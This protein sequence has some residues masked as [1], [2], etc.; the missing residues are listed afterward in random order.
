MSYLQRSCP[1]C[2][3]NNKVAQVISSPIKA[4]LLSFDQ[5]KSYWSGFFKEKSFFSY[6]R[7][8]CGLLYCPSFFNQDQL[9]SLYKSMSDN[10]AGVP[11]TALNKTQKS[12]F[13]ILKKHSDLSGQ[14]LEFGPDIGLFTQNCINQGNFSQYWLCEPNQEVWNALQQKLTG[15]IY[16]IFSGMSELNRIPDHS[17][18]TL[19]MIHVLDHLLD[20]MDTLEKIKTKLAPKATLM[21]VTHDERSF[22]A[23][24]AKSKW[25]PYCLQHPQLFNNDSITTLLKKAGFNEVIC[26]KS[27]NYFPITYLIKHA[28]YLL[29]FKNI[30]LPKLDRLQMG[31]KLGNMITIAKLV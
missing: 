28:L 18:S 26:E 22:L 4:E 6:F 14:Y 8:A 17:I 27:Y 12:Y 30:P 10:T 21:M 11:L 9:Q 5:I 19:T 16:N 2:G 13:D 3:T 29:G 25:P 24:V 20:P 7:C 31:L 15:K 23:K 1:S